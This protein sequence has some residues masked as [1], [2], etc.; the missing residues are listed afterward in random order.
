MTDKQYKDM[1]ESELR[2]ALNEWEDRV[3]KAGGWASANFA[4]NECEAIIKEYNCRGMAG[5]T[6][7]FERRSG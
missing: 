6:T 3:D 7:L 2:I 1:T 4:M 5:I